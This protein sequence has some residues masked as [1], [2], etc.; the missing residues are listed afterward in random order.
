VIV[1]RTPEEKKI[2]RRIKKQWRVPDFAVDMLLEA[3]RENEK[4]LRQI[5]KEHPNWYNKDGTLKSEK[6]VREII[7]LEED[8]ERLSREDFKLRKKLLAKK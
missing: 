2:A 6:E 7:V 8:P 5:K 1:K 4:V 3:E